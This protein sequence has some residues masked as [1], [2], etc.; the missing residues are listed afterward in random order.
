VVI[1]SP[2]TPVTALHPGGQAEVSVTVSNPNTSIVTIGLLALDITHGT[3]GF[4]VDAAHSA[5]STSSLSFIT[6]T[7]SG[8]GWPVPAEAGGVAGALAVS[9]PNALRMDVGAANA[10]QGAQFTV[11]LAAGS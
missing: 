5:C 11:Y 2:A 8:L 7:A 6:Q 10:C 4:A 3:G 9:L 1:L